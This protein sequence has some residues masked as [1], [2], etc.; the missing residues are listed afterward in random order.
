MLPGS[1]L[2]DRAREQL[3]VY[4]HGQRQQFDLPLDLYGTPFQI[5]VWQALRTIRYG[6]TRSYGDI[7]RQVG[8]P[9]AAR[10]VGG[11]NNRNPVSVIVPCHR[12]IGSD[13]AL[14]GYGGGLSI[15]KMLLAI[16][17]RVNV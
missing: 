3:A 11:A 15:K 6:T 8:R 5:A 17:E 10:A 4:F 9:K 16:E 2:L 13:G 1:P 14:V 12:V 7:A